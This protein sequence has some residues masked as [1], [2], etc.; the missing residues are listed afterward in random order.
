[1]LTYHQ[2]CLWQSPES[3]FTRSI[4]KLNLSDVSADC[5]Y[6]LLHLSRVNELAQKEMQHVESSNECNSAINPWNSTLLY[7]LDSVSLISEQK[8]NSSDAGD[9]IFRFGGSIPC[10]LMPWLLKSTGHQQACHWLSRK[11][12][13]CCCS[14]LNFTNLGQAKS[15]IHTSFIKIF[16]TIQHVKS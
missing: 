8:I 3:N 1:M 11:D 9:R 5:T 13:I 6:K 10:L 4:H 2:R 15:K 14:R 7:T 16:E 12:S